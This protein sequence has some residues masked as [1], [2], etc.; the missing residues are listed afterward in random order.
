MRGGETGLGLPRWTSLQAGEARLRQGPG[1]GYPVLWEYRRVGVPLRIIDEEAEWR[2]VRDWEGVEGWMHKSLLS[3]EARFMVW[4]GDVVLR[5]EPAASAE[6]TAHLDE[7]VS[8]LLLRC[9]GEWCELRAGEARGWT[10]RGDFFGGF[11]P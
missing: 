10:G 3:G 6:V 7:G 8:G 9:R 5:A 2:R 1:R 11:P 4:G